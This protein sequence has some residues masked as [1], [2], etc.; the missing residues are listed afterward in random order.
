MTRLVLGPA[1]MPPA[2]CQAHRMRGSAPQEPNVSA[3]HLEKLQLSLEDYLNRKQ[4]Q[5]AARVAFNEAIKKKEG[6]APEARS[7][8]WIAACTFS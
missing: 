1:R 2:A 6:M 7:L 5:E 3:V 8:F 4:A